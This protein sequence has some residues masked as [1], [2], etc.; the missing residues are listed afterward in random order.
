VSGARHF[1][2]IIGLVVVSLPV[3]LLLLILEFAVPRIVA[4]VPGAIAFPVLGLLSL[5]FVSLLLATIEM[6]IR[7]LRTPEK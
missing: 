7:L 5:G 3:G 6:V 4:H 2:R 1:N